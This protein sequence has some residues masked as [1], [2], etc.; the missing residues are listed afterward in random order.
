MN[1]EEIRAEAI[2]RIARHQYNLWKHA[3]DGT[4]D[5]LPPPT[6]DNAIDTHG[7]K[8]SCQQSAAEVVDALGDLLPTE[9]VWAIAWVNQYGEHERQTDSI[10][11]RADAERFGEQYE[12]RHPQLTTSLQVERQYLTAWS[13]DA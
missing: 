3:V 5:Y 12:Q 10:E 4:G 7:F 2:D 13:P 11:C 6:F 1:A 9:T 8:R